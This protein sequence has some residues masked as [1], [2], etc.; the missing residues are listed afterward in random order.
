MWWSCRELNPGPDKVT[1]SF[2]HAYFLFDFRAMTR[3]KPTRTI[4]LSSEFRIVV[5]V[6]YATSLSAL[7]SGYDMRHAVY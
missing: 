2:L 1:E 7:S 6:S 3:K 4:T 5:K